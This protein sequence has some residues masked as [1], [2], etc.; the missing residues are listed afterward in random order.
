MF[1]MPVR[2][3]T[4]DGDSLFFDSV[5]RRYAIELAAY[6]EERQPIVDAIQRQR[7]RG[8][9]REG[10]LVWTFHTRPTWKDRS[11]VEK[12]WYCHK[13]SASHFTDKLLCNKPV[14]EI[15]R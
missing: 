2:P 6:L 4:P 1:I 3:K 11:G 5:S 13:P 14:T 8:R 15:P 9:E 7:M 10:W 12:C